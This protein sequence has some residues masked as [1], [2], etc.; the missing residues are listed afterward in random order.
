MIL[1]AFSI[2]DSKALTYLTP[3]FCPT[4]GVA[5]RNFEAAANDE[6]HAF[7]LHASDY[8][9]FEIGEFDD[10]TAILTPHQTPVSLGLAQQF[11]RPLPSNP[12]QLTEVK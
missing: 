7:H 3:F 12:T 5:V 10:Q 11:V 2:F 4:A 8:G 6:G 9:L 1:K